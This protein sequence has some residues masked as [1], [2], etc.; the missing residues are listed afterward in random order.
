[1]DSQDSKEIEKFLIPSFINSKFNESKFLTIT[2]IENVNFFPFAKIDVY[3]CSICL[4]ISSDPCYI[5]NCKH[6]FCT[7]CI[8]RWRLSS[9]RCPYCRG[10]IDKIK[11]IFH[12]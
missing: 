4:L 5:L 9:N 8:Q 6:I 10:I 3:E 12:K 1:M 2:K 7:S 11:R